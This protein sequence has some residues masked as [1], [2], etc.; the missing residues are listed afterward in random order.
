MEKSS[1]IYQPSRF[2]PPND[3]YLS[4]RAAEARLLGRVSSNT[5]TGD[6]MNITIMGVSQELII[7]TLTKEEK[8]D[9]ESI[10]VSCGL[11]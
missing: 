11:S 3:W 7:I 10:N 9:Y 6:L 4:R 5:V 1:G 8:R 2:E